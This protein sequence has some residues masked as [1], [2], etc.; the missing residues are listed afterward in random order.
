MS[1]E[2]I[3]LATALRSAPAP[4]ARP[5]ADTV[6]LHRISTEKLVDLR[7]LYPVVDVVLD[8]DRL[9]YIATACDCFSDRKLVRIFV[10]DE[11]A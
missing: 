9:A 2:A 3:E 7:K 4:R 1:P 6:P 11:T 10:L 8:D 5:K